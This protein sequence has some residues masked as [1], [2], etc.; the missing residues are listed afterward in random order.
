M[1]CQK[2]QGF[3]LV[4]ILV[5]VAIFVLFALGIYGGIQFIFKIVYQSRLCILETGIINEQIELIRNISFYDVGIIQGNPSGVLERTVTTTRNGIPFTIT[6][7][8]RNIDDPFDGTIDGDPVDLSPADYKLVDIDIICDSCGQ[9]TPFRMSTRVAPKYLEGDPDHG[10][11]FIEVFDANAQPVEN[12]LV[13]VV[14]TT[15]DPTFDFFDT[16]DQNGFLRLVDLPSAFQSYHITVTKEGYT[17]DYTIV[18]SEENPNPIRLPA[19]VVAQSVTS[20][21]FS[22]DQLSSIAFQSMNA[23]CT[24]VASVPFLLT[25]TKVW[26]TDPDVLVYDEQVVT[27]GV[28]STTIPSL[29]WDT[30]AL[31]METYDVLGTIPILPFSALPGSHI[32]ASLIVGPDTPHSLVVQV[33]DSI[34][35]QPI[36]SAVVTISGLGFFSEYTTGIGHIRQTDWSQGDGQTVFVN[37]T[38]YATDDGNIST[39]F[40]PGDITLQPVVSS[41]VSFGML[42]SSII[43]LQTPVNFVNMVIDPLSQP[44]ETGAQSLQLQVATSNT[45]TLPWVYVGHDGT[46]D[47]YYDAQHL[48]LHDSHDDHRYVRYKVFLE[49]ASS[50]FTPRLSDISITYTNNCTP[51]GQVYVGNLEPQEYAVTVSHEGYQTIDETVTVDGDILFSVE[52]FAEE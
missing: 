27:D 18:P 17:S 52:L 19:T 34:T 15:T 43:D 33:I 20:I 3:T 39:S 11:L 4:E 12:A 24:P 37:D 41:Y 6:R 21:S 28:G 10:A 7:T 49:T 35:G 30:Y 9:K 40:T 48:V 2:Q 29:I 8:I 31:S 46:S 42:E 5:S 22:I 36:P 26:G 14:A 32:D 25:G 38:Q 51:P 50:T 1:A 45:T 44:E 23:F 47:T 16:T 13:H